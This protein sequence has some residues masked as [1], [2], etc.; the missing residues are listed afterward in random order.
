MFDE[1]SKEVLETDDEFAERV[2][3]IG[4]GLQSVQLRKVL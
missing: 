4:P 2:G 3:M 1:F